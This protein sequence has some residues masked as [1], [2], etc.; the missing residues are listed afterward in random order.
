MLFRSASGANRVDEQKLAAH[1]GQRLALADPD[2]VR[3]KAGY[4]IGGVPPV[5]HPEPLATIFWRTP[6]NFNKLSERRLRFVVD[7]IERGY[8]F[9]IQNERGKYYSEG[10]WEILGRPRTDGYD[11]SLYRH[12]LCKD[13][14]SGSRLC[15][16]DLRSP[17]SPLQTTSWEHIR[18]R[19]TC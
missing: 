13:R 11:A 5:G 9:V 19:Q 2:F 3:S 1:L 16:E 8:A 10:E 7:A 14:V 15:Q 12:S 6:Y 17:S 18:A 4:A